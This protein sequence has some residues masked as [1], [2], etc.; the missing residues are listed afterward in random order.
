MV[1]DNGPAY[2]SADF[3]RFIA[4]RSELQHV[5]TRHYAPENNGVVERYNASLKYE[6][7]YRIEIPHGQALADAVNDYRDIY[8]N[9]RPHEALNFDTPTTAYLKT[10]P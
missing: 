10:M 1:T 5:R 9:V 6:H 4:S 8:N 7:L 2:K 3:A